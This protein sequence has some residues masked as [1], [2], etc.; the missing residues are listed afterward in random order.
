MGDGIRNRNAA[1][2]SG[3]AINHRITDL[4]G[5]ITIHNCIWRYYPFFQGRYAS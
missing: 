5:P 1:M 3:G 4:D 2:W